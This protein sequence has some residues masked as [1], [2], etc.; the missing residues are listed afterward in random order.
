MSSMS[1]LLRCFFLWALVLCAANA[2]TEPSIHLGPE[3]VATVMRGQEKLPLFQVSHLRKGDKLIVTTDQGEKTAGQWLVVL[4]TITPVSNQTQIRQFDLTEKD[5]IPSIEITSDDQ[6]PVIVIAPQVRTLFGLHTSFSESASL[7]SDAIKVDPQR[8]LDLQK[9]DQINHAIVVISQ[10]LDALIQTRKPEQAIEAAKDLAAKFGVK[11]VSPACFKD[12]M[13]N[14]RC[15]AAY[16]VSSD[17]LTV[18]TDDIWLASGPNA[19]SVKLPTELFASLKLI[20]DTGN[21]LVNKY[22][23]NYDFA[24]SLG[25]RKSVSDHI[26]LYTNARFKSG[27]IKTAYAYVPS[28]FVGKMPEVIIDKNAVCLAKGEL[29]V[30]I[31][32][33]LPLQNYWHDWTLQLR[34]HGS[35]EVLTTYAGLEFKPES[36]RIVFDYPAGAADL[37]MNGQLL[38]ATLTGRFGFSK[39]TLNPFNL[40]LPTN[41]AL[42]VAGL[43]SLISGEQARLSVT[44]KNTSAC[45]EQMQLQ[46]DGRVLAASTPDAPA[47][48]RADLTAQTPADATLEI[49]QYGVDK[50][51]MAVAIVQPR[52]H[53]K[54]IEHY[55]LESLLTVFGDNLARIEALR[56]NSNVLCLPLDHPDA[57]DNEVMLSRRFSCPAELVNNAQFPAKITVQHLEQQPVAFAVAL[58]KLSARPHMQIDP[59]SLMVS[60]F[61]AKALQWN[62]TDE[63][64][65]ITEDSQIGA[66]LHAVDGYRLSRGAYVLQLKFSDDPQTEKNPLVVPLMSDMV[67]NELRSK[68]PISFTSLSLP[69]IVNPVYYRVM[70]VTSGL[71]SDWQSL[72]RAVVYFPN[73]KSLSCGNNGMLIHGTQL[74]LL[75]WVSSDLSHSLKSR[76][77]KTPLLQCGDELCLELSGRHVGNKLKVKMHWID[78]RLFEVNFPQSLDCTDESQSPAQEII[79][80]SKIVH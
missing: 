60:Q 71:A 2:A 61:S 29:A 15:V 25:Q 28:W 48:L 58:A 41:D 52:A 7:I 80:T 9:I 46:L 16:I 47:E 36:G 23:D 34:A 14:T 17:D 55:D 38:D 20:T 50:Q 11:Y 79:P 3:L 12:S 35:S 33:R 8:F 21:Y 1:T 57:T 59:D 77:K 65:L 51:S 62:L 30:T 39:V 4:A 49:V 26:Q 32:G 64:H 22:G 44:G 69:S 75:D 5:T 72:E 27:D 43:E 70:H 53:V 40:V 42:S 18:S 6:V 45:V 37:T 19:A 13:V 10:A 76:V 68:N 54:R 56:I 78:D 66:L 73:M 31:K 74:E 24:P 67:H 63:D